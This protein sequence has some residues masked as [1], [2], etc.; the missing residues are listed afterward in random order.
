[1]KR[2]W[3]VH[4]ELIQRIEGQRHWDQ[5]YQCLLMWEK[6]MKTKALPQLQEASHA[7]SDL[8]SSINTTTGPN[9]EH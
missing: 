4:R 9:T 3:I 8:C 6:A 1:M 5:V 7:S 2:E